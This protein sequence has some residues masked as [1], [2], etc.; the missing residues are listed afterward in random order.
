MLRRASLP[1]LALLALLAA[2]QSALAAPNACLPGLPH[3]RPSPLDVPSSAAY[4]APDGRFRIVGYNDMAEML[5]PMAALFARNH[6]AYRFE[7]I[8]KGTRTAPPALT[9]GS[10]FLAPMGAEWTESNLAA[11]RTRYGSDPLAIRIA[12]DSIN[13]AAI[14]SPTAIVVNAANPLQHLTL[15]QVR[16]IFTRDGAITDWS[17]LAPGSIG[18]IHPV[19]LADST[20]I[21][22]FLRHHIFADSAFTS[23]YAGMSQSR[24]VIAQV[25]SDPLAI[26]L[27]NLNQATS[28]VRALGIV[29]RPGDQ[30][31]FGTADDIRAGRYPLDR[32]LL[33]YVRR[34][35]SG[36]VEPLAKA[37]AEQ[38]LSCEGQAIIAAGS[39][40]YIPLNPQDAANERQ[41][42]NDTG[43]VRRSS[44]H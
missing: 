28:G 24:A 37:W 11:F 3:Y 12:H 1:L 26:G 27:A 34:D 9:D 8:L 2:N 18:A 10:S 25:A 39:L 13:P 42:L 20:A 23:A 19:G 43:D 36:R 16:K 35:R 40:G 22:Q 17:Q 31:S 6:P 30:P 32:H 41:K 14:S 4:R 5:T 38:L 15:E 29:A 44:L 7:L 33:V 21:G